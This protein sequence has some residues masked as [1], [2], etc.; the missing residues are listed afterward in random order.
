[1]GFSLVGEARLGLWQARI[2]ARRKGLRQPPFRSSRV[3]CQ[4]ALP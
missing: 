2:T 1:M 3:G 4:L